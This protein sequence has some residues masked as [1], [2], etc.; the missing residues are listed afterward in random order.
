MGTVYCLVILSYPVERSHTLT[1]LILAF[2][3]QFNHVSG[4][5][6]ASLVKYIEVDNW[7]MFVC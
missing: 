5:P 7:H 4:R 1:Y 3:Y 6:F 2:T